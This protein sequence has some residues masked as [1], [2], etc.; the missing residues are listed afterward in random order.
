MKSSAKNT[1]QISLRPAGDTRIPLEAFGNLVIRAN[2]MLETFERE[3]GE[4]YSAYGF[5]LESLHSSNP[6]IL[7]AGAG[8]EAKSEVFGSVIDVVTS[9]SGDDWSSWPNAVGS[10]ACVD[11]VTQFV[12][13]ATDADADAVVEYDGRTETATASSAETL[14]R[15]AEE[16]RSDINPVQ[17][18]G[19]VVG[20]LDSINAHSRNIFAVWRTSDNRRFECEFVDD[21]FED[22]RRLLKKDVTVSGLVHEGRTARSSGKVTNVVSIREV[23]TQESISTLSLYGGIPEVKGS[24]S[25]DEYWGI[26][27]GSRSYD[28]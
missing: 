11:V 22:A 27:R 12:K 19:T 28:D 6:T 24:L 8:S 26:V 18:L 4:V 15:W 23:V 25:D 17:T 5:E 1:M 3:L 7:I 20:Q 9:A 10:I 21:L 13:T 16:K 14:K 2:A